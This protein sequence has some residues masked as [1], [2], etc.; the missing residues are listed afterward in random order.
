MKLSTPSPDDRRADRA[1]PQPAAAGPYLHLRE[2]VGVHEVAGPEGQDRR[3][4]DPPG[5]AEHDLERGLERRVER[6]GRR[7]RQADHDDG[8]ERREQHRAEA[9]P[10]HAPRAR[11]AVHL[12]Q[13]VVEDVA[14]REEDVARAEHERRADERQ[15]E[16]QR[17]LAG[18][19]GPDQV[20]AEQHG[21]EARKHE[22]VV[23]E[24]SRRVR[25]PSVD[26]GQRR[27]SLGARRAPRRRVLWRLLARPD[28]GG[29]HQPGS[30]A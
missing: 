23:A 9:G 8:H 14:D 6:L 3:E 2:H 27:I 18:L 4:H 15:R 1:R 29:S 28:N 7:R 11:V 25:S 26:G 17:D 21:D 12:G 16:W 30:A 5:I 24:A 22:I 10:D 19:A 20:R 13:H